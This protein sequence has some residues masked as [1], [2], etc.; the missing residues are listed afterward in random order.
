M[1]SF[2]TIILAGIAF[3]LLQ[4]CASKS[5]V[6]TDVLPLNRMKLVM[7][8]MIRADEYAKGFVIKDSSKTLK[9]HSII[10]YEKVFALH[11]ITR[12][13]FTRSLK[14]YESNPLQNKR[15][16]DSLSA[17]VSNYYQDMYKGDGGNSS[18]TTKRQGTLRQ[19]QQRKEQ[20]VQD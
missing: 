20:A 14:Y 9:E 6:P 19:G 16:F 3:A 4:A 13:T 12:E 7:W 11:N 5:T 10:L 18:D 8:D 17:Q 15:L 1:Q 2:K